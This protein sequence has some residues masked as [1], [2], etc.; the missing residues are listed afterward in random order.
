MSACPL[1]R[2]VLMSGGRVLSGYC[3]VPDRTHFGLDFSPP[4]FSTCLERGH[5]D[6]PFYVDEIARRPKAPQ[7][8]LRV[9]EEP[10]VPETPPGP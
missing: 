7:R 3:S 9:S 6:C 8:V 4:S 5:A 1:F 2:A 10:D